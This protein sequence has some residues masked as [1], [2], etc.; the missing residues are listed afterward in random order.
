MK[1]TNYEMHILLK[2]L[3]IRYDVY[4][5]CDRTEDELE[6]YSRFLEHLKSLLK[7]Q[8]NEI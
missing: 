5:M 2:D 3:Q 8:S 1:L 7:L 4:S 6:F